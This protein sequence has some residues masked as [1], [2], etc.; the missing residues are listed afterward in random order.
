MDKRLIN[1]I[2]GLKRQA[3]TERVTIALDWLS[4]YFTQSGQFSEKIEDG[5][6]VQVNDNFY[7]VAINRPTLHFNSMFQVIQDGEEVA[8]I[9]V[10][11]KNEKFFE[12]NVVKV[13]IKNHALYSGAWMDVVDVLQKF[14]L[15]YKSCGRIDIAIDGMNT[16][17][18]LLNL[19]AKQTVNNKTLQLK[20]S[21]QSRARFSAK[22]LNPQTMLFENF[23]IGG[24][25]GNKMITIYNKSLDIVKTGKKY[26]QE[27]WLRNGIIG[28]L[29]D[30]DKQASEIEKW[31]AKGFET[32]HLAGYKNIYRF[33]IRLKSESIKE[34]EEFGLEM[35]MSS[36]GLA[37]IVKLHCG[38][39][40]EPILCDDPKPCYC[41][42]VNIIPFKRLRAV[43]LEKIA[44]VETDG[45]YKAKITI[46]GIIQDIYR[47]RIEEGKEGDCVTAIMDRVDRYKLGHYLDNK[48]DEWDR[49]YRSG[50]EK[51]HF[52]RV[53]DNL[54]LVLKKLH[55]YLIENYGTKEV[56]ED[57]WDVRIRNLKTMAKRKKGKHIDAAD[58]HGQAGATAAFGED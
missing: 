14:G 36:S 48:I 34:I 29:E 31:E 38:K 3:E 33:E 15:R 10:N 55:D 37:G 47:C 58:R 52:K 42:P 46:H 24:S 39:F 13:E 4:I 30:L 32:F 28:E 54:Y 18:Q 12:K 51:K 19:Y 53:E 16:M 23:N 26:I 40:F 45:L 17:H 50:I 8:T 27:Y 41:S 2:D 5:D 56:S 35:L 22:V 21:S 6:N 57:I 1:R 7:L 20:N 11:S 49:R 25:G 44:R 43:K 9:L